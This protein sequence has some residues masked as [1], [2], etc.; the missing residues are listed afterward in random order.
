VS[1]AVTFH[2]EAR[3]ELDEAANF[4]NMERAD[5]ALPS[6]VRS[7]AVARVRE[8]PMSCPI[9]RGRVRKMR[10]HRFPYAVLYSAVDERIRVL[11]VAHDRRRPFYWSGRE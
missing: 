8:Y 4:Y 10:V 2:E 11:A 7:S 5:S 3:T 6:S 1:P 9:L